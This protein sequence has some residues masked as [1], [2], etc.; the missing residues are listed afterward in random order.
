MEPIGIWIRENGEWSLIH[1]CV[2]CGA[3]KANRIAGDDDELQ[4]FRLAARP[5]TQMPFPSD[6][7]FKRLNKEVTP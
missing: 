5:V 4:L 2:R 7:V 3:M 6:N 1:R